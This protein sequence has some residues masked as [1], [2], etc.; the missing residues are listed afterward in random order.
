MTD[1]T[2][3]ENGSPAACDEC[4]TTTSAAAYFVWLLDKLKQIEFLNE[5]SENKSNL[6]EKLFQR[7]PDLKDLELTC[8]NTKNLI[9][10]IDLVN[11][12]LEDLVWHFHGN[13]SADSAKVS[14]RAYNMSD[15]D[16]SNRCID[17]PR[18]INY[19]LYK[20]IMPSTM[21][22][23]HVLPF[24]RALFSIRTYLKALGTSRSELLSAFAKDRSSDEVLKR[25][26]VAEILGLSYNDYIAIANDEENEEESEEENEEFVPQGIGKRKEAWEYWGYKDREDLL[27]PTNGA[28]VVEQLLHRS[29]LTFQE[30]VSL[31][32]SAYVNNLWRIEGSI[33]GHIHF[34]AS[35]DQLYQLDRLQQFLRLRARLGWPINELDAILTTLWERRN[36][37]TELIIDSKMLWELSAVQELAALANHQPLELQP[38]WGDIWTRGENS[39]YQVLFLTGSHLPP[40]EQ[41]VFESV[42]RSISEGTPAEKMENHLPTLLSLLGLKPH[43]FESIKKEKALCDNLTLRNISVLYRRSLICSI[44]GVSPAQYHELLSLYKHVKAPFTS[45]QST[46]ALVRQYLSDSHLVIGRWSLDEILF[47]TGTK[48]NSTDP[49]LNPTLD[50]VLALVISLRSAVEAA[51]KSFKYPD[52]RSPAA[53]E[54]C[55]IQV[56][57]ASDGPKVA[58]WALTTKDGSIDN[59][60]LLSNR[61]KEVL[62]GIGSKLVN[63]PDETARRSIFLDAIR[64][65]ITAVL[66]KQALPSTIVTTLRASFPQIDVAMLSFLLDNVV[67]IKNKAGLEVSGIDAF[68]DQFQVEEGAWQEPGQEIDEQINEAHEGVTEGQPDRETGSEIKRETKFDGYF[69]PSST[70]AYIITSTTKDSIFVDGR[71]LSWTEKERQW[72]TE[73]TQL[74]GGH[75]SMVTFAGNIT[76]LRLARKDNHKMLTSEAGVFISRGHVEVARGVLASMLQKYLL[77]TRL[78]LSLAEVTDIHQQ[79]TF[80][81]DPIE[82]TSLPGLRLLE[83]YCLLRDEFAH[84]GAAAPLLGLYKWLK[85]GRINDR[86][87]LLSEV[88][89]EISKVTNWS[90]N[91]CLSILGAKFRSNHDAA[92]I[93]KSLNDV[94]TLFEIRQCVRFTHHLGLPGISVDSLYDLACPEWPPKVQTTFRH[95]QTLRKALETKYLPTANGES[96]LLST[97][98]DTIRDAQRTSLI[99]VLL[100]QKYCVDNKL[101]TT[102]RLFDH[103][104]ID[105]QMGPVL[106]TSRIKQAISTVQVFAQRCI[107]GNEGLSE[108]VRTRLRQ[109]NDHDYMF[110][111]RLWE[112]SRKA[113]LFPEQYIDPTLRDDKSYQFKAAEAAMMQS[114]LDEESTE[115]IIRDYIHQ[116]EEVLDLQLEAYLWDKEHKGFHLF[117][118]TRKSPP[119]FY[120]RRADMTLSKD[121]THYIPSWSPWAKFPV[122]VPVLETDADGE[123]LPHPGSYIIPVIHHNRLLVFIPQI[124]LRQKK[125]P[126]PPDDKT[127]EDYRHEKPLRADNYHEWDIRLGYSELQNGK[128]SPKTVSQASV[129]LPISKHDNRLLNEAQDMSG[130]A[131]NT[132]RHQDNNTPVESKY[133]NIAHLK[134]WPRLDKGENTP[135]KL[136]MAVEWVQAMSSEEN[137][138]THSL[139][140]KPI[141]DYVLIGHKLMLREPT[142]VGTLPTTLTEFG[143]VYTKTSEGYSGFLGSLLAHKNEQ[144]NPTLTFPIHIKPDLTTAREEKVEWIMSLDD[145]NHPTPTVL[146]CE[147]H[148]GNETIQYIGMPPKEDQMKGSV[149]KLQRFMNE[150]LPGVIRDMSN[151]EGLEPIYRCIQGLSLRDHAESFGRDENSKHSEMA[152]PLAIYSWELGVHLPSLLMERLLATHQLELALKVARLMYDHSRTSEG[153]LAGAHWTFPPFQD[154]TTLKGVAI[155]VPPSANIHASARASPVAYV[156]RIALKYIEILVG[157]GDQYFRQS[158]LES[159]P[160]ALERYIEA[161]EAFSTLSA[162]I[163]GQQPSE[164]HVTTGVLTY[165][166]IEEKRKSRTVSLEGSW[167]Y[168]A[169]DTFRD[170]LQNLVQDRLYKIRNGLDINGRRQRLPLFAPP[171]DPGALAQ[172]KAAPGGIAGMLSSLESP[173][174]NYRFEYLIRHAFELVS[175]LRSLEQQFFTIREKKDAE[176]LTLLRS[177]HQ[178]TILALIKKVKEHEKQEALKAIDVISAARTQQEKAMEYYLQ[179]TADKDKTQIPTVGESWKGV[180]QEIHTI[181]GDIPMSSFEK[182]ELDKADTASNLYLAAGVTSAVGAVMAAIPNFGAKV[183]P[184]GAGVDTTT[185]GGSF[186]RVS[187]FQMD[188]LKIAAQRMQEEA[189]QAGRKGALSRVLQERRQATNNLGWELVRLDKERSHLQARCDMCDAAIKSSQQE[190]ENAAAEEDWLRTKYTGEQLYNRLDSAVTLLSHQ[191]YQLALEMANVAQRALHFEHSLRFPNTINPDSQPAKGLTD[192]WEQSPDGQ[193][194]GEALYLDLKR[195]EM[196][197]MENRTHDFEITKNVSIRQLDPRALLQLREQGTADFDLPEV[198][199]D[200]DF[201]GQYCRRIVSVAVSIP[202]ILGAYTSLNCTLRLLSHRYRIAP[203]GSQSAFYDQER[204]ENKFH[205]DSIPID[206]VAVSNGLHDTGTFTLDFNGQPRYG[207]FEGAGAI[208][209]WRL[210]FPSPFRQFDY[211]TITDVILHLR[212]TAVDGGGQFAKTAADAVKEWVT[213]PKGS[214]FAV[215]LKNEYPNQWR[216]LSREGRMDLPRI[217]DRLPFW[218]RGQENLNVSSLKV[219]VFPK[220][221]AIPQSVKVNVGEKEITAAQKVDISKEYGYFEDDKVSTAFAPS[222]SING[223]KDNS[224]TQGWLLVQFTVGNPPQETQHYSPAE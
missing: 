47:V 210:Q 77:V 113:G 42:N 69:V 9:P 194:A 28:I 190:I 57:D 212:Y 154:N 174:P 70:G 157:L 136:V 120:Y 71:E 44:L 24:N 15:S 125:I 148:D 85:S 6:Q 1:S 46:L 168:K 166:V 8:A 90:E 102:D 170:S 13:G 124:T 83:K 51:R 200:M 119:V 116:A 5:S 175:E 112:A 203:A 65:Q 151:A 27:S 3:S 54:S 127:L 184:M 59:V 75:G 107:N 123:K 219:L 97:A 146:A 67:K 88:S 89:K 131:A 93:V 73:T 98:N 79:Q 162:S 48:S 23:L 78:H 193:L 197:H 134:F 188:A 58:K 142:D 41:K 118:R 137:K 106:Q 22:P 149:P 159:I 60:S 43:E 217:T 220:P 145:I 20:T 143:K 62:T 45:P 101:T 153:D 76:E 224:F 144:N 187:Y 186:S 122:E 204:S 68:L 155:T 2:T 169:K 202:C 178:C 36:T 105:F 11:E 185:G 110:R 181:K 108:E 209:K 176:G 38:L 183:Q 150:M 34:E 132:L 206:A 222:W 39:L 66:E 95:A 223:F 31:Q 171:M 109:G 133:A 167:F 17:R 99:R 63:E 165:G 80:R 129:H 115:R 161:S 30:L 32:R 92:S 163:E 61:S 12:V 172:A 96:D 29:G 196:L 211:H 164:A 199:F 126:S 195:M 81:P 192:Y 208:S 7:R 18:N 173:M 191:T 49:K 205:S 86:D 26:R 216:C 198:L 87:T 218:T 215:D 152:T 4:I 14:I 84:A 207:P 35:V 121:K 117:G 128:W 100:N 10:Y 50:K 103:F 160:L 16:T 139:K 140:V 141:A 33:G 138:S 55:L 74:A 104:L 158:T 177:R 25:A 40:E 135:A 182:E 94:S 214:A 147:I 189:A 156:K 221:K 179:L 180:P 213:K 64:P 21:S 19:E 201:P 114:K 56:F 37:S 91:L 53:F 52:P 82:D 72:M 130:L 111:Y